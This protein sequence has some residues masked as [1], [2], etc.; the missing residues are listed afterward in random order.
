MSNTRKNVIAN[1]LGAGWSAALSFITIP[2]LLSMLGA[3]TYGLIALFFAIKAIATV[4]DFGLAV[5]T[6]REVAFRLGCKD[7]SIGALITTVEI[8]YWVISIIISL[9]VWGLLRLFLV[10]WVSIEELTSDQLVMM[11]LLF[12][13]SLGISFPVVL[14]QN[15]LRSFN[16]H[17][18]YNIALALS[19]TFRNPGALLLLWAFSATIEVFMNWYLIAS[20]IEIMMY[21]MLVKGKIALVSDCSSGRFD[22]GSLS[23]MKR[24]AVGAGFSSI[25]AAI[26]FQV[27]KVFISKFLNLESLGYYSAI[28]ALVGAFGKLTTPI[29]TAVF[30]RLA[31]TY[32]SGDIGSVA[33]MYQRYAYMINKLL[34]PLV[35]A[36]IAFAPQILELWLPSNAR[37]SDL[38]YVEIF[39]AIAYMFYSLAN[40]PIIILMV[41]KNVNVLIISRIV[42]LVLLVPILLFLII[43]Y[44]LGGVAVGVLSCSVCLYMVLVVSVSRKIFIHHRM[45]EL[46]MLVKPLL[47]SIPIFYLMQSS[48]VIWPDDNLA[49]IP[50]AMVGVIVSYL[51][52]FYSYLQNLQSRNSGA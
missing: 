28:L 24:F 5:T 14:Y 37:T 26:I 52:I 3:E 51:I 19:A 40:M 22:Y 10:D 27:D 16:E 6:N 23:G 13:V 43:N 39:L 31:S 2:F 33:N 35:V 47:V 21:W 25:I 50:L 48:V 17:V 15:L 20:V 1:Y 32:G 36:L 46:A 41:F 8:L 7:S 42:A 44:G 11:S 30:P 29:V 38:Y 34:V 4:F 45:N 49:W 9:I 12:A 18:A